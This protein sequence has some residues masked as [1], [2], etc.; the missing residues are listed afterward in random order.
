MKIAISSD[1]G[2]KE[3]RVD[4]RF[5]RCSYFIIYDTESQEYDSIANDYKDSRGG[6]GIQVGQMLS[7]IGVDVVITGNVGPNAYRTLDSAGIEIYNGSGSISEVIDKLE[8]GELNKVES[9]TV[10]GHYGQKGKSRGGR[11]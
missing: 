9:S 5:G 8:E 2:T 11:R 3:G 1:E 10:R 4:S 7:N 6:A